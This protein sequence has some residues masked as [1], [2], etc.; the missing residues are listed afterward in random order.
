VN[1]E[2]LPVCLAPMD[3][4][5]V[6]Q[7]VAIDRL[8]FPTPWSA[9]SYR[10]EILENDHSYFFV[11]C[12]PQGAPS[13]NKWWTR[14]RPPGPSPARRV[15]GYVGYWHVADEAHISTIAVH[16]DFRRHKIGEQLLAAA[17]QHASGQGAAL[18]TLEVRVSNLGAFDL[19]RKF[20]FE[21]VGRRKAYYR[22][23]GEDAHLMSVAPLAPALKAAARWARLSRV[24]CQPEPRAEKRMPAR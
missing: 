24:D 15:V 16:P 3:L 4:S 20:G 23:N 9:A 2:T 14:L 6:E 12:L 7:V 8:S 13:Q 22:D 18:A 21:V 5:D 1:T 10:R 17:L 19:Y 11:A